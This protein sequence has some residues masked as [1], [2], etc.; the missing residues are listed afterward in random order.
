[1]SLSLQRILDRGNLSDIW[2]TERVVEQTSV[3]MNPPTE[4]TVPKIQFTGCRFD[5]NA[6]RLLLLLF[7]STRSE[8][9]SCCQIRPI[10]ENP[11]VLFEIFAVGAM[12]PYRPYRPKFPAPLLSDKTVDCKFPHLCLLSDKADK[13]NTFSISLSGISD[14]KQRCEKHVGVS[15]TFFVR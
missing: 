13:R 4:Q 12:V 15:R 10:R 6:F 9:S 2:W 14:N 3:L 7:V 1:M 8:F 5:E 11:L